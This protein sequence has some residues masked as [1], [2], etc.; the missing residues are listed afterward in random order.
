MPTTS[1]FLREIDAQ[2][3]R[4]AGQGR[5]NVEVNAGELHRLVGGYPPKAGE[6]HAVP[7]CCQAMWKRFNPLKDR[8]IDVPPSR[9]GASLTLSYALPRET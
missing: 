6:H 2:L 5:K 7:T 3:S 8:E 9:K 4:A 1:D